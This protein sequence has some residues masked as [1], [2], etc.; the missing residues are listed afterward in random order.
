MLASHRKIGA[1]SWVVWPGWRSGYRIMK[2]PRSNLEEKKEKKE[3]GSLKN[4]TKRG[5]KQRK[6]LSPGGEKEFKPVIWEKRS[7]ETT[8]PKSKDK[9]CSA[10]NESS[11]AKDTGI[12]RQKKKKKKKKRRGEEGHRREN[13]R[14]QLR[15]KN[16]STYLL[17]GEPKQV[18]K[19]C[20]MD[21]QNLC[22]RRGKRGHRRN[23][24]ST[25]FLKKRQRK[26]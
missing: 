2:H 19:E 8:E 11:D 4:N 16:A 21:G 9:K 15:R 10:T 13:G 5:G 23:K 18:K 14:L 20:R 12:E 3:R 26:S 6:W 25:W 1:N 17:P 22:H 24:G 7:R